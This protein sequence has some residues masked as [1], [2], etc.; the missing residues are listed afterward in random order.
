MG[1]DLALLSDDP[2]L[3][4][5]VSEFTGKV[6]V[7]L[8]ILTANPWPAYGVAMDLVRYNGRVAILGL[9]GR[10]EPALD[11]NPLAMKWLYAKAL[12][13]ISASIPTPNN[14]PVDGD[15]FSLTRS[16]P[17]LLPPLL[18]QSVSFAAAR[19]GLPD[20]PEP[21]GTR[22]EQGISRTEEAHHPSPGL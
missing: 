19:P 15:R 7:D 17:A 11:F 5:K 4:H 20:V 10:G 1:A 22:D 3:A 16:A 21:D 18:G 14:F 8:V 2:D 13:L 6:G 9:P 12:T